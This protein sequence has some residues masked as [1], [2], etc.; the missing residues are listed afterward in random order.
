MKIAIVGC[1]YYTNYI[2]FK[3]TLNKWINYNGNITTIISG[4]ALG[5]D[6]LAEKYAKEYNIN[7]I[8]HSADW[9]KYGKNAGLIRNT[10]IVNDCDKVIAFP[11]KTSKGTWNTINQA[12]NKN[13][14]VIIFSI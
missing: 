9:T 11:S 1:Q 4:G 14:D 6:S 10:L 8:V 7:L 2:Y 3:Q 13:K 5:V 12:K